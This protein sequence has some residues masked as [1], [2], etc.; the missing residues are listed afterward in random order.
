MVKAKS[1]R[2]RETFADITEKDNG[3]IRFENPEQVA[4]DENEV[5]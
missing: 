2:L 1:K 3:K 4:G 5:N